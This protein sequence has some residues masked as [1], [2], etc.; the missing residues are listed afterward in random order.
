MTIRLPKVTLLLTLL[1]C[2]SSEP[3]P[4]VGSD[5]E[6]LVDSEPNYATILKESNMHQDWAHLLAYFE[7]QEDIVVRI[8]VSLASTE[9]KFDRW[10]RRINQAQSIR[11]GLIPEFFK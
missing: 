3:K 9:D 2:R 4:L 8:P 10:V 7:Q 6:P 5:S 11:G 1:I